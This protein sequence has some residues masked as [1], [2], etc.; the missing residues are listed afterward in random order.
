MLQLFAEAF[1]LD[2]FVLLLRYEDALKEPLAACDLVE[3]G[4]EKK[5]KSEKGILGNIRDII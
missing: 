5:D 3:E 2:D 4:T 1:F